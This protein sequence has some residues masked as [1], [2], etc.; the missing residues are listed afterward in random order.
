MKFIE[1]VFYDWLQS[2]KKNIGYFILWII[3]S[4]IFGLI[5]VWLPFLND[6]SNETSIACGKIIINGSLSTYSIVILIDAIINVVSNPKIK[7]DYYLIALIVFTALIFLLNVVYYVKILD[8]KQTSTVKW[9]TLWLGLISTLL[10]IYMYKY[11]KID[12]DEGADAAIEEDNDRVKENSKND[13]ENP[14]P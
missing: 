3:L 12:P 5:G 13:N 11:K 7:K 10:S 8:N 4:L 2:V 1:E 6:Y 9:I 14:I